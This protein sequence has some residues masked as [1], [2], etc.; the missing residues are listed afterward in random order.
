MIDEKYAPNMDMVSKLDVIKRTGLQILSIKHGYTKLMMPIESNKNHV[1]IM[2]AGSLFSL[3]EIVGGIMWSVMF[4]VEK[5]Y[6]VVKEVNIQFKRPAMTDIF[7]EKEFDK[8]DATRIQDIAD[9]EG[10]ADY[11]LELELKDTSGEIVAIVNG[12]WQI[13][14]MTNELRAML[15]ALGI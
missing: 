13:R 11:E 2:Y 5:C 1:G 12:V 14:K 15:K 7:L 4:D 9:K 8:A 10:K 6:P 3:G